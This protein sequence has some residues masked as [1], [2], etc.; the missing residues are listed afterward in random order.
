MTMRASQLKTRLSIALVVASGLSLG[1]CETVQ[2]TLGIGKNP[3]DEMAVAPR[4]PLA[5]PP[6]YNLRPPRPGAP[7]VADV[8]TSNA[9]A[10]ALATSGDASGQPAATPTATAPATAAPPAAPP[11]ESTTTTESDGS[12]RVLTTSPPPATTP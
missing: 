12:K 8:N 11:A 5:M 1:A 9:A 3:P 6:D 2:D 7:A 10:R 4:R